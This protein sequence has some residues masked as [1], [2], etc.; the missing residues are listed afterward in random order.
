MFR[1]KRKTVTSSDQKI[2]QLIELLFP[3]LK[4]EEEGD[5]KF[6]VDYGVDTNLD[7]V[8]IDLEEGHN[9]KVA[10]NTIKDVTDRLIK[11]R[12]L[13]EAYAE[14]HDE[15]KYIIVDNFGRKESDLEPD[16]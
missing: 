16:F 3:P 9:D 11:A 14:I 12:K 13:L 7:A 5:I 15:A 2:E 10:W 1:I 6:H 4:L 8:L